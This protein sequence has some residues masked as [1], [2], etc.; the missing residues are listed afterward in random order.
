MSLDGHTL[1]HLPFFEALGALDET[2]PDW[3]AT[4]AGLVVLRQFDAWL[5]EGPS[6]VA[7]ESWG[8]RAVREAVDTIHSGTPVRGLLSGIVDAM[9]A[10]P[11]AAVGAVVP[12][13]MAYA[14]ALDLD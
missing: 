13:L 4:T 2:S 14:R 8:T 12:R 1:R 7:P 3:A 9:V 5:D 6:A 10:S 11:V